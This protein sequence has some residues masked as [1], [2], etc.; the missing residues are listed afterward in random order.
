MVWRGLGGDLDSP[1]FELPHQFHCSRTGQVSDVQPPTGECCQTAITKHHYVLGDA[2]DF[3]QPQTGGDHSFIH[4]TVARQGAIL[5]M[6][7]H[8]QIKHLGI[9]EGTPHELAVRNRLAVVAD[10]YNSC[11]FELAVFGQNLALLSLTDGSN[12]KDSYQISLS[13]T[14]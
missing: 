5:C 13:S 3:S 8:R 7:D 10:R 1:G 12:R 4:H 9:L 11:F 6:A 2:G 14:A